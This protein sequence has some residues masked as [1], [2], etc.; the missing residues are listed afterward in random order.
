M[1]GA[2]RASAQARRALVEK[3][4]QCNCRNSRCLKLYCE[5]FASGQYCFG[6]NCQGCHNNPENNEKRARAIDATLERNPTAFRPKI[7]HDS[8]LGKDTTRH[9]KGCHCKKSGCLKKYCECFQAGVP[10]APDRMFLE[11]AGKIPMPAPKKLKSEAEAEERERESS[12]SFFYPRERR[13][14]TPG[15]SE[16]A[17]E[18]VRAAIA[19]HEW[20]SE[21]CSEML[22][23]SQLAGSA[24]GEAGPSSSSAPLLE[25]E[26]E[27][28]VLH[29]LDA[30][31]AAKPP[32]AEASGSG[33]SEIHS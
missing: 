2:G 27:R 18:R 15:P 3:R 7:A 11:R 10:R 8:T 12:V 13:L 24:S 17:A 20:A 31:E 16:L 25:E 32:K 29:V 4:G 5:C 33:A 28:A 26:Q 14:P 1:L 9:S 22:R 21:A 30:A 19:S 23:A 6:C